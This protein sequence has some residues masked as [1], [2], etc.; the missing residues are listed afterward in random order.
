MLNDLKTGKLSVTV[1][2]RWHTF[3]AASFRRYSSQNGIVNFKSIYRVICATC[4][5]FKLARRTC[6]MHL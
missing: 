6:L 1:V 3:F 2:C 5:N 4:K